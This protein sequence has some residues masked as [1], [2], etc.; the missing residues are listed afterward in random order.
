[1]VWKLLILKGSAFKVPLI[2]IKKRELK[3]L[4]VNLHCI[5]TPNA[6]KCLRERII[7]FKDLWVCKPDIQV[8]TLCPLQM[9][10]DAVIIMGFLLFF[11]SI[12]AS[13]DAHQVMRAELNFRW[14]LFLWG[15][16]L[17]SVLTMLPSSGRRRTLHS[18]T[19]ESSAIF[20]P[21]RLNI[22]KKVAP[23]FDDDLDIKKK[24][25]WW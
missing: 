2:L 1:M 8:F 4:E 15:A 3:T 13:S 19:Q 25:E 11:K 23:R 14:G 20:I 9:D 17:L 21:H 12:Q 22:Y 18:W 6:T 24:T 16:L 10:K 5:S 7:S